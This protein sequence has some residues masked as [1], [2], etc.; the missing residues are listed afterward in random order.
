MTS[1]RSDILEFSVNSKMTNSPEI[2]AFIRENSTLFWWIK[3]EEKENIDTKFLVEQIL[4]YG[5]EKNVKKLFELVGIDKV[6]D[7]FY[8]Q[9]SPERMR[10]NYFPQV[11]N[12]F[13][14]YFNKNA[15]RGLNR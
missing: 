3:E 2:K 5:D 10:V 9:T 14:I 13:R 6:A 8:E 4:N 15:H 11:I 12:F 7:I 1:L